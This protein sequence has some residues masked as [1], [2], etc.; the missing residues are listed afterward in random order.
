MKKVIILTLIG[1]KELKVIKNLFRF[2]HKAYPCLY[3]F[4]ALCLGLYL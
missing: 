4:E 3:L 1:E 2:R